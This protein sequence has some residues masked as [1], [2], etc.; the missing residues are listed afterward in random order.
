M[1]VVFLKEFSNKKEGTVCE[2]TS[3]LYSMLMK[4]GIVEIYNPTKA[5]PKTERITVT[6]QEALKVA[7]KAETTTK[8]KK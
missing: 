1:K 2:M 5:Q 8:K 6:K 4:E 3:H 7:K